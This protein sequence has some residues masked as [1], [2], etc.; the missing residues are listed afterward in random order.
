MHELSVCLALLEEVKR[1]AAEND[2]DNVSRIVVTIGPL[3][4]VEADLLRNAYPLAAAG[5]LAENAE[6]E[7]EPA[8]VIVRCS[9]CGEESAATPN[10]LLCGECGD[11]RTNLVSGDEM[12]LTRVEMNSGVGKPDSADRP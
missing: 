10:K 12:I 4:G 6:L 2:A 8:E 5:T 7:I 1:V 9:Q 3:S 11:Y